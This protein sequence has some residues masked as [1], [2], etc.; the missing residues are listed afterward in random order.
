MR[1]ALNLRVLLWTLAGI[2]VVGVCVHF[3]H[4]FQVKRNAGAL[5]EYAERAKEAGKPDQALT[6]YAHYLA[7]EPNDADARARLALTL[8]RHAAPSDRFRV[9]LALEE[10]LKRDVQR[11]E[12]RFRLIQNLMAL[13]RF[14]D[15]VGQ[16][17]TLLPDW[18]DKAEL[19][20]LTGWCQEA[21]GESEK[22]A[23]SF[24]RAVAQNPKQM[25]SY[26]LRAELLK[27]LDR[28]EE[29]V[30]V[31]D[32]LVDS[33]QEAWRA[34]LLRCR[35]RK[36]EGDVPGA[37]ADLG[38]A[39]ALGPK[40]ADVLLAAADWALAK[41][42]VS[43][44][45]Q[46]VQ[47]GWELHPRNVA[48]VKALA[49]LEMRAGKREHAV[50]VLQTALKDL[51]KALE[52]HVLLADLLI[53]EGQSAE[54][55]RRI[56]ELRLAGMAPALPDY[57][58]AR[59]LMLGGR[60]HAALT[61]LE[62]ARPEL[63][64][65]TDW[66]SRVHALLGVCYQ[67]LGDDPQQLASFRRAT[68]LE[69]GWTGAR[70]GLA[71]ALLANGRLD[72]GLTELRQLCKAPD[73][74]PELPIALAR[75]LYQKQLRLPEKQRD[76]TEV[77]SAV[78]E[79]SKLHPKS[80]ELAVQRAE[81]FAAQ[82][83]NAEAEKQLLNMRA[84]APKEP[85]SWIAL[86]ELAQRQKQYAAASTL[87]EQA[88]QAIGDR[89]VLRLAHA[90]LYAEQ[91]SAADRKNLDALADN[92]DSF[93]PEERAQL[94]RALADIWLRLG[95][96]A[97]AEAL[98][99][100]VAKEQPRD[101]CSRFALFEVAL[102]GN[103]LDE[104]RALAADLRSIEGEQ[105]EHWR[106][107]SAAIGVR[108]AGGKPASLHDARKN[109]DRLGQRQQDWPRIPLLLAQIDERERK[110][111]LALAH[112]A[113]AF[114]LGER[115][116]HHVAR[117]L[118]LTRRF[119][120]YGDGEDVLRQWE[121]DRALPP[122]LA[123]LG[124]EIALLNQ[125]HARALALAHQA[126]SATTRDYRE[127]VWLGRMLHG[128]GANVQ[129][130]EALRG[131]ALLAPKTPE[132]WIALVEQLGRMGK[133]AEAEA[134]LEEA[135]AKVPT[136]LVLLTLAR[137]NDTLG[138]FDRAE[139]NFRQALAQ[140]PNDPYLLS[141]AADFFRR[142]DQPD[143]AEPLW[144]RLLEPA[145]QSPPEYRARARR[146]LA[147]YWAKSKND[148]AN[149]LVEV[150]LKALSENPVDVRL[151]EIVRA[152]PAGA[153]TKAIRFI[154]ESARSWPLGAD[155]QLQLARL[156]EAAGNPLTAR[157]QLLGL[158]AA[159]PENPQFLAYYIRLLIESDER[160]QARTHLG[161]L[162]RLEPDSPRTRELK[163]RLQ[164]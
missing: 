151:R 43:Q 155:E 81:I 138:R 147:L 106:Y 159:Q 53:D 6:Y 41:G 164:P 146:A 76:W 28:V 82:G 37:I 152:A 101:L 91:A 87:L 40:E 92:L 118:D 131:A 26:V 107:A 134:V 75:A 125:N 21:I 58:E 162:E 18:P 59:L 38:R 90:R 128:V 140:S 23:E 84:D 111:D 66:T 109:L 30:K 36:Q 14:K 124:A 64:K 8:D 129:A 95:D 114:A 157:D 77:E 108:E 135:K 133:I 119:Q 122:E 25:E 112:Y 150:N 79:A 16:L 10:A 56:D 94:W 99:Q 127:L 83:N 117:L 78:E 137:G 57:L 161:R 9:V 11:G 116:T 142:A 123:R 136:P 2:V 80:T 163:T 143:K 19:E 158:L 5:L 50:A 60:W 132:T 100:S 24:A 20:H 74:P 148:A 12:L 70:F 63:E 1:R 15:A 55:A 102:K 145:T 31:L 139:E 97:R 17:Q 130:E 115:R 51:P 72:E 120:R 44:A 47:N 154:E 73:A 110:L 105:G 33:N 32:A 22:A 71:V 34:Y 29:A 121:E 144:P 35:F 89:A 42:N 85:A 45:R 3:V 141:Q 93:P 126:V 62:R 39:L 98:W 103:R 96:P 7:L 160:D 153:W 104:A 149:A 113:Q 156:H 46:Y 69:P 13:Q 88:R 86:A 27:R 61:L 67:H 49:G 4:A 52:L 68:A 54:A 48:I 65:L